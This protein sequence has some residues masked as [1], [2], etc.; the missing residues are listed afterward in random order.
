MTAEQATHSDR[1]KSAPIRSTDTAVQ[2]EQIIATA[3]GSI[4]MAGLR[5][6]T[7]LSEA[8]LRRTLDQLQERD[9][10]GVTTGYE[11]VHVQLCDDVDGRV[12]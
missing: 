11:R 10:V 12:D 4:T 6:R 9:I 2:V 1:E 3:G 7:R 8:A 5:A